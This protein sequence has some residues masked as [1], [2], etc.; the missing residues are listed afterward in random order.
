MSVLQINQS[1][2]QPINQSTNQS[3]NQPINQSFDQSVKQSANE[4]I[5]RLPSGR[6]TV[7]DRVPL[8]LA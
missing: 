4:P 1:T 3:T 2:D 6:L 7:I 8:L 5:E